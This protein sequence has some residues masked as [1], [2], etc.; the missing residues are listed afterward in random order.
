MKICDVLQVRKTFV[1]DSGV[2]ASGK[3][4]ILKFL[5]SLGCGKSN[6]NGN[7]LICVNRASGL[8]TKREYLTLC[9]PEVLQTATNLMNPFAGVLKNPESQVRNLSLCL[10]EALHQ[11]SPI[12]WA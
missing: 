1:V 10:I 2:T 5:K 8:I 11:I 3:M 9:M 7:C 6:L 12:S 4:N